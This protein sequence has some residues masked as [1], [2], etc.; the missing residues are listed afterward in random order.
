MDCLCSEVSKKIQDKFSESDQMD[1]I[2]GNQIP[3]HFFEPGR[4]FRNK[5]YQPVKGDHIQIY[6][7]DWNW[8]VLRKHWF[9]GYIIIWYFMYFA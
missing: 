7:A 6:V 4:S 1:L 8:Q 9:A 2:Q 5:N 3:I